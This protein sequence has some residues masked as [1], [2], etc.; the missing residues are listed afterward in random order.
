LSSSRWFPHPGV[1]SGE[2][3]EAAEANDIRILTIMAGA[4]MTLVNPTTTIT[5]TCNKGRNAL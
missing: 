4:M 3:G 5:E 2:T 1:F